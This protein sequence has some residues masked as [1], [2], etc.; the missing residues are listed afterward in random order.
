MQSVRIIIACL[1][2]F[3]SVDAYSWVP[4]NLDEWNN[5]GYGERREK[6]R[7]EFASYAKYYVAAKG[8]RFGRGADNEFE[9]R[10][11][12]Q[13]ADAILDIHPQHIEGAK[14]E[15][16]KSFRR[17][18]DKMIEVAEKD[19]EYSR[20]HPWVVGEETLSEALSFFCPPPLWPICR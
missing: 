20:K 9:G 14:S 18:I 16:R 5:L 3:F 13:A 2:V 8:Y 7:Q 17:L 19:K 6:L 1:M 10:F 4:N 11:A 15:I 12:I